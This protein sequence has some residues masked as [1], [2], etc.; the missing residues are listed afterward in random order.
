MRIL[1][2][3]EIAR[4]AEGVPPAYRALVYRRT[5]VRTRL[6]PKR[7][8]TMARG[9]MVDTWSAASANVIERGAKGTADQGK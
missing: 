6:S 2:P 4:V 7:L 1:T 8:D 5:E 3:D 9:D